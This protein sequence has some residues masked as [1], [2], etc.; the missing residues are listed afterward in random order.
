MLSV[1]R[2][3]NMKQLRERNAPLFPGSPP[4]RLAAM[5]LQL[6]TNLTAVPRLSHNGSWSSLYSLITDCT[7]NSAPLLFVQCLLR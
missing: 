1:P 3:Y 7:E 2:L 5:S 6:T 4:R